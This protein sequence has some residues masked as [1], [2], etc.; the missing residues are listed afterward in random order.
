MRNP[1][2]TRDEL[3]LG[4]DAYFRLSTSDLARNHPEIIALSEL[5]NELPIH[6]SH[7]RDKRFRNPAGVAMELRTFL[8]FDPAYPGKGLERGSKLASDVWREFAEHRSRLRQTA[9]A[10]RRAFRECPEVASHPLEDDSTSGLD[11]YVE[12][13]I[14]T[15]LHRI[16]ERN[17]K[18]VSRK[19]KTV[20]SA[21]GGLACEVC[22]FDF[23]A[24]YGALGHGYAE[25]H[26]LIPLAQL[27][28]VRETRLQDLA[29]VCAN[30]HRMFHRGGRWLTVEDLRAALR[31]CRCATRPPEVSD[32]Q[33]RYRLA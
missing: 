1:S 11:V 22:G 17:V 33:R 28:D 32:D 9:D 6:R 25:C 8:T 26:H 14:L 4:L 31:A 27:A 15:R 12:G 5:L 16:R 10:I 3:I 24:R 29:I 20:L 30:C 21:T 2:W 7:E 13:V 23:E 19:K 18:A